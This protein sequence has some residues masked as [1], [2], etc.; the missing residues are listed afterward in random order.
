MRRTPLRDRAPATT[1]PLT[2]CC[3]VVRS[4]A[5]FAALEAE[6]NSLAERTAPTPMA[7]HEWFSAAADAFPRRDLAVFLARD[8]QGRLRG[9]AP[10]AVTPPGSLRRLNWLGWEMREPEALLYDHP[11]AL[12]AIWAEIRRAGLPVTARRLT[13]RAGEL[14]SI[15]AASPRLC[16]IRR[17]TTQTAAAPLAGGWAAFEAAMSSNSRSEMRRKRRGLEKLGVV[18]FHAVS[19]DPSNV[20]AHLQELLRVEAS[21]WKGRQGSA[22][23]CRPELERF[24]RHYAA[25]TAELGLLRLF[26]LA[27]DGRNIAAQLLVETGGRLWQF[28]IGYDEAWSKYSPG[29]L[30]MLDIIRWAADHDLEAVEYLG[31]GGGWQ[32]RWPAEFRDHHSLR[33]YPPRPGAAVAFGL[34]A[35]EFVR[36]KL[37]PARAGDAPDRTES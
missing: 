29:R 20:E 2:F 15:E 10:F 16:S 17:G 14:E 25:G 28:K 1:D 35:L 3:E 34:D 5:A 27:L 18:S 33:F 37:D 13:P 32:T 11:L 26:F 36:R 19:P 7:R 23:E 30:L 31:H 9:A 21:G 4:R 6:W 8:P 12:D 24:L 22:I